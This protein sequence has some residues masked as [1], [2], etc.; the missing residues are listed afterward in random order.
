MFGW[1]D[2]RKLNRVTEE[3]RKNSSIREGLPE[4]PGLMTTSGQKTG[5]RDHS[6]VNTE[7]LLPECRAEDAR[8]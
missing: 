8:S 6:E 4:A 7:I 1:P 5:D 2:L 3:Q